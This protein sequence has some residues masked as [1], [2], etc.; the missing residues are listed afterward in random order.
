MSAMCVCSELKRKENRS[1]NKI[2]KIILESVL[3][4]SKK[5]K[6]KS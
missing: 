2:Q 4:S 3:E 6:K 1:R 5:K